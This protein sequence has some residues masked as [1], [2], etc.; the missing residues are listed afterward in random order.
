MP[1][2]MPGSLTK[3]LAL[4]VYNDGFALVQEVRMI[5]PLTDDQLVYYLDVPQQIETNSLQ[6][7]GLLV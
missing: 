2:M 7:K 3:D 4:T 6:V 1:T 5:P